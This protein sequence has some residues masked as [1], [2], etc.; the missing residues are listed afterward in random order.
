MELAIEESNKIKMVDDDEHVD[1]CM[2]LL[3]SAAFHALT[4]RQRSLYVECLFVCHNGPC[5][6][7]RLDMCNATVIERW[8][9]FHMS[10]SLAK[11]RNICRSKDTFYKDIKRL[12]EVGFI[13]R[14]YQGHETGDKDLWRLSE[15][16]K[17]FSV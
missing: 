17:N 6:D 12:E 5:N 13:D 11:K 15:R 16:W 4:G 7:K 10:W 3:E 1:L 9:S 14:I 8:E 2:S